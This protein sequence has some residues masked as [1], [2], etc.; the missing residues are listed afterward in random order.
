M[1]K[2]Y[3]LSFI[4]LATLSFGQATDLYF[5][6]YG[7]GSG[8]NKFLE[9]YNGTGSAVDLSNY[10]IELY[11]NGVTAATNT[12]AFAAGT[13][14]ASGDVYVLYA[15][16]S[17]TTI[18]SASDLLSATCNFNGDDAVVLKKSGTVIDMIGSVGVDPGTGWSV[19]STT[20]GTLNHT[21]VRKL[22]VCSPNA[23]A[24]SSFGTDDTTSEWIVYASDAEWAQIGSHSG[25]STTINFSITS[26]ANTAILS[27]ETTNASVVLSVANF[28]VANGTGNGHIKY[29]I[30]GGTAAMKYDTTP[31][32][33]PTTPGNYTVYV[34]LVDNSDVAI[35]PAKNATVTFT[36]AS[37]SIVNDLAALRAD[38]LANDAGK[39]YQVSSTPVISYARSTRNQKYIQDA[40]AG[41]LIDDVPGTISTVMVAGDAISGLKG[42]TSLF[43]GLLQLLP[44]ENAT[45]A[46]SG[47]TITPQVVT[48]ADITASIETYES[49]LVQ[50]NNA[51][52]TTADGTMVFA[53]NTNYNLNDGSDIAFRAM[54]SE[55][56]YIG[57][58]VPPGIAN[59]VVLVAEFNG[60]AQVASR[61]LAD[62]T[63]S[64]KQNEIS[65]L[66][67]YPN[68]VSNG[69]LHITSDSNSAK[70]VEIYDIL[71]KQV[72]N[73]K[74]SNNTVNVSNLKG[75]AYIVKINEEGK[76][77]TRKLI[78]E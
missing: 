50:I 54:F 28:N 38:V 71:G 49:E 55:A 46:S 2:L 78:I 40:T 42:Q 74:V 47:N 12:Q 3:T 39:Y 9:I 61:S 69:N 13:M 26:P 1:K 67:M 77:A 72:L 27:P 75:G 23:V 70:S 48:A 53:L 35:V 25:C 30:N 45:V 64:V 76:T 58:I 37:Y 56:N 43:N 31:I 36:V 57:Q 73:A 15:T 44:S 19:G 66:N 51:S 21:M 16:G 34:E 59:R 65:G 7:E 10:S 11:A 60:V 63:L 20:L 18:I 17:N 33:V 41:I 29:T 4:L 5:S 8:S 52:F 24:L 22:T 6:M 62:T 68:P 14:I 32:A